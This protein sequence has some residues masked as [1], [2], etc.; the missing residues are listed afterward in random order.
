MQTVYINFHNFVGYATTWHQCCL[1]TRPHSSA[2]PMSFGSRAPSELEM[3]EFTVR[4]RTRKLGNRSLE[5]GEFD[6]LITFLL[7]T[8]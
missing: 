2:Q 1:V 5:L 8:V 7:D 6:T 3:P 4:R